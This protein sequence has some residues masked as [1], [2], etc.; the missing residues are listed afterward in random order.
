M[1]ATVVKP[2]HHLDSLFTIQLKLKELQEQVDQWQKQ[3]HSVSAELEEA[4]VWI[5][6]YYLNYACQDINVHFV[7]CAFV[8]LTKPLVVALW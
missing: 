4:K 8:L 1:H 3:C 6:S 2:Y 5:S 7:L